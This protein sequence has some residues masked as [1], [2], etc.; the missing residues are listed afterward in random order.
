MRDTVVEVT[1][2]TNASVSV[3]VVSGIVGIIELPLIVSLRVND[4]EASKQNVL[5]NP[6]IN[7]VN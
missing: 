7:D 4:G 2:G 3:C 6:Y 5:L 1:E